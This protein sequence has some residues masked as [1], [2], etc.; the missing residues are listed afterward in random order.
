MNYKVTV[1][2]PIYNVSQHVEKCVESLMRQT[3]REIEYIFIDDCAQDNSFEILMDTISR[4]PERADD[5]KVIRHNVNKGLTKSRN[6]GLALATGEFIAHCDGDDWMEETMYETMYHKAIAESAEM[7]L[8]DFYFALAD[9]NVIHKSR[10]DFSSDKI[11]IMRSYICEEWNTV[12]VAL[13]AKNV[14]DRS[15]YR[16]PEDFTFTEDFHLMVRLMHESRKV[17]H[18]DKPLYYYN[19]TNSSSIIHTVN[20][21]RQFDEIKCYEQ[22]EEWMKCTGLSDT[23]KKEMGWRYLKSKSY[24]VSQNHFDDFRSIHPSSNRYIISVPLNFCPLKAKVKMVLT[25]LHLD[26]ISRLDNRIHGRY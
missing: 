5:I 7:V 8:C 6:D 26:F 16:S 23:F 24:F 13:V 11:S 17:S 14:Y 18:I 2:V 1:I 20:P 4:Y 12:W 10:I 15:G 3:L 25:I 21:K 9:K 19:Q 22:I